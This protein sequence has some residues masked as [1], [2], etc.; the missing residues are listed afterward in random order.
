MS[1]FQLKINK[2]NHVIKREF[3]NSD[4]AIL[5]GFI[6]RSMADMFTDYRN[7]AN[8]RVE[9]VSTP[10]NLLQLRLLDRIKAF[11]NLKENWDSYNAD[12]ISKIAIDTALRVLYYFYTQKTLL[13]GISVHVF[14]MRDG[15]IQ[16]EFDGNH[17]SAELEISPEGEIVF[18]FFDHDG[19]IV[20][21]TKIHELSEV[22]TILLEAQ[23]A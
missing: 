5:S 11:K 4:N 7:I 20:E 2:M 19:N 14:P 8:Y 3:R 22:S 13:N 23:Y 18:L 21:E 9:L 10:S 12:P 6:S 16:F 15:G 17:I 1:L